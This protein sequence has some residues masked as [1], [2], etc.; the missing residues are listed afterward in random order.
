MRAPLLALT[1]LAVALPTLLSGCGD[2][3]PPD[4]SVLLDDELS[5]QQVLDAMSVYGAETSQEVTCEQ[6]CLET[7]QDARGWQW[8]EIDQCTLSLD[9]DGFDSAVADGRYQAPVG[10]V[11]CTGRGFE[12]L[13]R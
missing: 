5:A 13:C 3:K 4:E 12:Y 7:Y 1:V 8:I 10:D 11:S 2:C 9:H 6:L